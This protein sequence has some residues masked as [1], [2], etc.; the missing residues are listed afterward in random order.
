VLCPEDNLSNTCVENNEQT[1]PPVQ[2]SESTWDE[3]DDWWDAVEREAIQLEM[4]TT[5]RKLPNWSP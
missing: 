5:I 4:S 3:D 1:V 2:H